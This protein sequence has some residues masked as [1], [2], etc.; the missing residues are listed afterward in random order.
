MRLYA[1][2]FKNE[3]SAV[4]L[5]PLVAVSF[6]PLSLGKNNLSLSIIERNMKSFVFK[7]IRQLGK[8]LHWFVIRMAGHCVLGTLPQDY[9]ITSRPIV[10]DRSVSAEAISQSEGSQRSGERGMLSAFLVACRLLM[11]P[12]VPSRYLLACMITPHRNDIS[13]LLPQLLT[14]VICVP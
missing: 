4:L 14:T 11:A 8:N 12:W 6:R 10:A 9:R 2:S 1:Q 7:S 3:D 13:E 5:S